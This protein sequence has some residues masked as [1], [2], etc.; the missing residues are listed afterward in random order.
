MSQDQHENFGALLSSPSDEKLL[1]FVAQK[2]ERAAAALYLVTETLSDQEPLRWTLRG[3]VVDLVCDLSSA[4][5]VG[6]PRGVS[7]AAASRISEMRSLLG[8]AR[9]SRLLSEMNV[10]LLDGAC[11]ELRGLLV[12]VEGRGTLSRDLFDVSVA[13]LPSAPSVEDI[14][15][16]AVSYGTAAP[17]LYDM[18]LK[19]GET[20]RAAGAAPTEYAAPRRGE[21]VENHDRREKILAVLRELGTTTIADIK[22]RVGGASG[23]TLQRDLAALVTEGVLTRAGSRRWTTYSIV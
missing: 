15:R 9:I 4:A 2:A 1:S 3:I 8:V 11:D 17:S 22:K 14:G 6:D 23:K 20:K 19:S 18:S 5:L 21:R 13:P 12:E 10:S 7:A 16:G